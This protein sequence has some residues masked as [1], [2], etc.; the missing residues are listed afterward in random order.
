MKYIIEIENEPF[1][2]NDDPFFPHGMDELYRA[3]G[4]KS[5]VFDQDGLNKLTPYTEPDRKAVEDE[6]WSIAREIAYCMSLQECI[7]TGMLHDDDIYDSASGV[8]EK[9]TYQEA[10]AKYEAWKKQKAEIRVGDEVEYFCGENIRFVVCGIDN[11]VAYG[12]RH[13]PDSEDLDIGEYCEIDELKKT[14]RHFHEVEELLKK[15]RE[16]D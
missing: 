9:L 14:G 6:V 8:L 13:R 5:L 16:E 15:M 3:K 7:D 12:F 1:G 11:G 10:K 4:F 2:R